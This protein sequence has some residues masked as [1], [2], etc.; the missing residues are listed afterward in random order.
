[1]R[2]GRSEETREEAAGRPLEE[3]LRLSDEATGSAVG[4]PVFALGPDERRGYW[5]ASKTGNGTPVEIGCT[6]N[7]SGDERLG[8]ILVVRDIRARRETE[9]RM[10]QAQR[11]EAIA[12]MAGGLAHDFNNVLM[13][14]LGYAE[15]LSTN[16]PDA[17]DRERATEIKK[18]AVMAG[19]ISRQ[20]LTLSRRDSTSTEVL[21][22][23]GVIG[24]MEPLI[25]RSLGAGRKL[26]LDLEVTAGAV[27]ADRNR[28]KQVFLN[29]ALN[30][31]DAMPRGG[32]L[33]IESGLDAIEAGSPEARD[34]RPGQYVRIRVT[35][36]GQGM[37]AAT[38]KRIFE[39]F[40]TTKQ[41]GSGTGLGLAVVHAIVTQSDG[42]V[43]AAS[44]LGKGTS[45]EILLPRAAR[46][47]TTGGPVHAA[48]IDDSPA[49]VLL[50]D[51]ED[52]VRRVMRSCLKREGYELLEARDAEEEKVERRTLEL[53]RAIGNKWLVTKGLATDDRLIVEG[54]EK[55]RPGVTVHA[56]PSKIGAG[57]EPGQ[58]APQAE[59]K[60]DSHV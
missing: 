53:D 2:E 31:R 59:A 40:F 41:P 10:I 52:A 48:S 6:E 28:L 56:V 19:S 54:A 14:I 26:K 11:M 21:D 51:D 34:C 35:D 27:R 47:R 58:P 17:Q 55:V 20:L 30:A 1:M 29:L 39:P 50:V 46:P 38:L 24:E 33:R 15:E 18:A 43:K 45:F 60:A 23:N 7:V 3:V 12:N 42:Y 13:V 22:I 44:E 57:A 32:E 8:S 9:S 4:S 49:T 16:L 25:V 36:S 37:D 5:L